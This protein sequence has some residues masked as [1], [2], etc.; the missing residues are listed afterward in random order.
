MHSVIA[1]PYVGYDYHH[2]SL[3]IW[4]HGPQSQK[5]MG[6]ARQWP[7]GAMLIPY[8]TRID[9]ELEQK[10]MGRWEDKVARMEVIV[11]E[12]WQPVS[13]CDL[14]LTQ[15]IY[16]RDYI[17]YKKLVTS[18]RNNLFAGSRTRISPTGVNRDM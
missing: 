18:T 13:K 1:Q 9:D 6:L 5:M 7:L 12:W 17:K 2:C 3:A 11:T 15:T 4:D 16:Y 14:Q 8:N 10:N